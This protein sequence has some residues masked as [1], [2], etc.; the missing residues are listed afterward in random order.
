MHSKSFYLIVIAILCGCQPVVTQIEPTITYIPPKQWVERTPSAFPPLTLEEKR[1]EWSK[2]WF[3]G[4]KFAEN[5]DFYRAITCFKQAQFL[6]N[7]KNQSRREQLSFC[8]IESYY[9]GL[10][11]REAAE[12]F[13]TGPLFYVSPSFPAYKEL[14]MIVI[15]S[16]RQTNQC[17]KADNFQELLD[18][19]NAELGE[20]LQL[21]FS[22]SEGDFARIETLPRSEGIDE[23]LLSY[24]LQAKSVQKARALNAIL[25]GAG[26]FIMW[27]KSTPLLH[28][29]S[30]MGYSQQQHTSCLIMDTTL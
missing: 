7:P 10:K 24:D 25:P 9:L 23:F 27:D 11:Y 5:V 21:S 13:E 8:V 22:L 14:L 17:K 15:D 29:L 18:Q 2:E 4:I 26:Y 16:Y 28:P 6:L 3:L 30:L 1:Q 20:K 19:Y 12:E